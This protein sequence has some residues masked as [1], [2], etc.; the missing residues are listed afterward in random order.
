M[1]FG[2]MISSA[3]VLVEATFH[4]A[5]KDSKSTGNFA[6]STVA[7]SPEA[8][9]KK[10]RATTTRALWKYAIQKCLNAGMSKENFFFF[11]E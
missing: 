2:S 11:S 3:E 10:K 7:T 1:G 4:E 5:Y 9:K 6:I 8:R